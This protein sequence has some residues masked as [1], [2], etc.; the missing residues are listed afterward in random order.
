MNSTIQYSAAD[1]AP[2][3][4]VSLM[5][6]RGETGVQTHIN[7]AL[8][9]LEEQ[10]YNPQFVGPE[11]WRRRKSY[12]AIRI[13]SRVFGRQNRLTIYLSERI[14]ARV[15]RAE[16]R[17]RLQGHSSWTVYAQDAVCTLAALSIKANQNQR[18]VLAV[19][20]NL[21]QAD[22]M[23]NRGMVKF[24]DWSYRRTQQQ[25][26]EAL[27]RADGV[28]YFSRFMKEQI[29]LRGIIPR[30]SIVI[31]HSTRVPKAEQE[32]EP[33]DLIAIGT[34]EPRK[35]QS[36]LV[37]V[38]YEAALRGHRYRLTVVGSGEDKAR[39]EKLVLLLGLERQVV[40][41]GTHPVAASL[42]PSH[43]VFVHAAK[44]ESFGIALVEALAA[45]L[46]ILAPKVGGMQEILRDGVEGYFWPLD[47]PSRGADL[48][49]CLLE[50]DF[51]WKQMSRAASARFRTSFDRDSISRR[52][53]S[54][55]CSGE[56]PPGK[57]D[58]C[59]ERCARDAFAAQTSGSRHKKDTSNHT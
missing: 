34:L 40:F 4:V 5:H 16:L 19:H 30:S 46:P 7:D 26:R 14:L 24:G 50:N 9:Y 28:L 21:S 41:V 2:V 18:V 8:Q 48:L 36:Y 1:P 6:R 58:F 20:F 53:V 17:S 29:R 57:R 47:S 37:E 31:P 55:I 44:M 39:L 56:L 15:L 54:Y 10:G 42:L 11:V 3:I 52:L 35:N 43:R 51:L 49:I 22:E 33:R 12:Y 23:A 45:G 27:T 25:E 38:L 32:A 13:L 59:A